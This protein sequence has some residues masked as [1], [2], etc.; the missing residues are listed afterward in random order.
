MGQPTR[1][2]VP[3]N[4]L[5]DPNERCTLKYLS[6]VS[7]PSQWFE[8]TC[9]ETV[10]AINA[11]GLLMNCFPRHS[12]CSKFYLASISRHATQ[13]PWHL[14]GNKIQCP[15]NFRIWTLHWRFACLLACVDCSSA[16][17]IGCSYHAKHSCFWIVKFYCIWGSLTEYSAHWE[18]NPWSRPSDGEGGIFEG[19][20][21]KM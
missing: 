15:C 17:L 21:R 6:A 8:K 9:A 4:C 13:L 3:R 20:P 5:L 19:S 1:F 2:P 18:E 16:C 14:S 7:N 10:G 11:C 12:L